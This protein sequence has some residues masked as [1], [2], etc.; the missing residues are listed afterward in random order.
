MN[1]QTQV[2]TDK[3]STQEVKVLAIN[4]L[5]E[6]AQ[7]FYEYERQH[8]SQFIG[9]DIFKVDGSIKAKYEHEKLSF[10]GKLNDGTNVNAHYWF[11]SKY[12][13]FDIHVKICINGGS[14]D[15]KPSTAFCQYEETALT[16]FKTEDNK[17]IETPANI[18]Y[19]ATRYDVKTLAKIAADIKEAAKIYEAAEDKMPYLFK[20]VFDVER[21]TRN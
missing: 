21:L 14:Y 15:V 19:L 18:D 11:T 17:L 20:G 13:C 5:Y 1:T 10:S 7:Q 9:K 3:K 6:Y 16:L 12:N 8:F 4:T 2:N